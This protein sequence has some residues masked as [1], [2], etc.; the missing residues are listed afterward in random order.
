MKLPNFTRPLYGVGEQNTKTFFFFSVNLDVVLSD[1]IPEN[2]ANFWKIKLK[3]N[4]IDEV[5]NY[6]DSLLLSSKNFGTM[7]TWGKDFSLLYTF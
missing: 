4:K 1:S 2:F 7:A 6:V 5:W 3:G